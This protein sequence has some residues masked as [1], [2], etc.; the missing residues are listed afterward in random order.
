MVNRRE[1]GNGIGIM[2]LIGY[3]SIYQKLTLESNA[4][5]WWIKY[6]G[7]MR[8]AEKVR[9]ALALVGNTQKNRASRKQAIDL[10]IPNPV[11]SIGVVDLHIGL[12]SISNHILSRRY[13]TPGGRN[14]QHI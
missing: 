13:K 4:I 9:L 5:L 12:V 2:Q 8:Y 6:W 3:S 10:S 11:L 1:T 7:R 14:N